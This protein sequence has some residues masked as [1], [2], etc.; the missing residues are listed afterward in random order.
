MSKKRR[1]GNLPKLPPE[2][3]GHAHATAK[4]RARHRRNPPPSERDFIARLLDEGVD[5]RHQEICGPYI[6]D[7]VFPAKH[8]A[9]E[10]DG[11]SHASSAE[12]DAHRQRFLEDCG[13]TVWR[14]RN[15]DVA[16]FP[17]SAITE[18]EDREGFG[19]IKGKLTARK[20]REIFK[21]GGIN[22]GS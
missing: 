12:R 5:F 17:I 14:V 3:A 8:L 6:V 1:R 16:N 2:L 4:Y 18:L 13:L 21:R 7:F 15:E 9:I 19:S 10:I 22:W 11:P 20:W